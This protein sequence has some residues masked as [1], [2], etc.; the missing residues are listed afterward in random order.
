MNLGGL[1]LHLAN[2]IDTH[3]KVTI[4]AKCKNS[5]PKFISYRSNN[6]ATFGRDNFYPKTSLLGNEKLEG[7]CMIKDGVLFVTQDS[8][9]FFNRKSEFFIKSN[10][11]AHLKEKYKVKCF[12]SGQIAFY[13]PS[14]IWI[15]IIENY[16]M[17][18][19]KGSTLF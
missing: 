15:F 5:P 16:H 6:L 11:L 1:F 12:A 13:T 8:V 3:F 4:Y 2:K 19:F 18:R 14:F 9:I 7:M 17:H 10:P